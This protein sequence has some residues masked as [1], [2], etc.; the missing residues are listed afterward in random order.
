MSGLSRELFRRGDL[1]RVPQAARRRFRLLQL[2]LLLTTTTNLF[3]FFDTGKVVE[4]M[5]K[6]GC[7]LV[8]NRHLPQLRLLLLGQVVKGL[9]GVGETGVSSAL[10][11]NGMGEEER[12][13]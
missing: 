8:F 6:K 9:P 13:L 7:V 2:L 4:E 10:V 12:V 1:A 11:R 5:R 3:S